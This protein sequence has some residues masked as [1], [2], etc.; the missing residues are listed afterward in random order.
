MRYPGV[1]RLIFILLAA[2]VVF[3][4]G[5]NVFDSPAW[6]GGGARTGLLV[7]AE[8]SLSIGLGLLVYRLLFGPRRRVGRSG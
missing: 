2:A 5:L 1:G 7:V 4:I 6:V 8:V 3:P